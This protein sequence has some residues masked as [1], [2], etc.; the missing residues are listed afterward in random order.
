[1]SDTQVER[2]EEGDDELEEDGPRQQIRRMPD[3]EIEQ[4]LNPEG[5]GPFFPSGMSAPEAGLAGAT[6]NMN[7]DEVARLHGERVV[8]EDDGQAVQQGTGTTE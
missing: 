6:A 8:T 1:M 3:D 4:A 2:Y 7:D 5:V